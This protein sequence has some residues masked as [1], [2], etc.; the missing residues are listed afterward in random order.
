MCLLGIQEN[1]VSSFT[2]IIPCKCSVSSATMPSIPTI[3]SVSEYNDLLTARRCSSGAMAIAAMYNSYVGRILVGDSAALFTI[4]V[5]DHIVVRGHAVFDTATIVDGFLY[6]HR[7]HIDRLFESAEKAGLDLQFLVDFKEKDNLEKQKDAVE[8]IEKQLAKAGGVK[9]GMIRLW[10]TAGPGN[11]GV[12]KAGCQ[13]TLYAIC[14]RG[15]PWNC[16]GSGEGTVEPGWVDRIE[17]IKEC[18]VS[19][20][21]PMKGK[22]LATMKSSNYLVN[23]LGCTEAVEGGGHYGIWVDQATGEVYEASVRNVVFVLN[24][25]VLITPP[26]SGDGSKILKGCTVR[27][28]VELAVEHLLDKEMEGITLKKVVTDTVVYK[29]DLLDAGIA[30]MFLVSGDTHLDPVTTWDDLCIGDGKPGPVFK[31]LAQLL[32]DEAVGGASPYHQEIEY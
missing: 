32:Y 25:G 7:V 31:T 15:S 28:I 10:L 26:Y 23:A 20:R 12:S 22:V 19:E 18:T 4:P 17:G 30:E 21:Y 24:S 6:R 27:R 5:D 9:N 1:P 2:P 29:N 14:Y 11:L 8:D 3:S 16:F 13:T